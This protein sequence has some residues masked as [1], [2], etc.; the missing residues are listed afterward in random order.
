MQ[1]F[2]LTYKQFGEQVILIEWPNL[3]N[4]EI[5]FDLLSFKDTL[6]MELEKELLYLNS[7]YSSIMLR[8]KNSFDYEVETS[9]LE[10][11]Y[12]SLTGIKKPENR[13]WEIPVC[14]DPEFGIDLETLAQEKEM[15]ADA[16]IGLHSSMEYR[17]Y[18]M[19]FLPGFLYLGG[20]PQILHTPRRQNPR[21]KVRKGAVAI[22]GEQTGIY[23]MESPGGWHII[24]NSPIELFNADRETPSE[25]KAGDKVKFKPIDIKRYQDLE[26]DIAKGKYQLKSEIIYD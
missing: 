16:I 24:G 12:D 18:F 17:V 19:G 5:L 2:N 7:A 11:L 26:K 9:R 3:I 14:Y 6:Q 23:P 15:S 10:E 1:K 8:Y 22:G 25:I 13:L 4:E 20:L 21:S